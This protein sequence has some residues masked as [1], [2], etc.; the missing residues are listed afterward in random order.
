[1]AGGSEEAKE[2]Y[3]PLTGGR[4]GHWNPT[5]GG[6]E[7]RRGGR[8]EERR[9]YR[10]EYRPEGAWSGGRGQSGGGSDEERRPPYSPE[11]GGWGGRGG[12]RVEER[13]RVRISPIVVG[14]DLVRLAGTEHSSHKELCEALLQVCWSLFL[15]SY[16]LL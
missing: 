3:S 1:M 9:P 7:G 12:G 15:I 2:P 13:Q 5:S 14:G 6:W 8:D 4:G 16:F 11:A 10:P